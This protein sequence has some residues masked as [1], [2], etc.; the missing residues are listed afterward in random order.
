VTYQELCRAVTTLGLGE[1]ASLGEIK[2][3][4]RQLVKLHH[5]DTGSAEPPEKIREINAAYRTLLDYLAEYR[6]SFDEK[7]FYEQ[8]PEERLRKQFAD[9]PLWGDR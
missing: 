3:R 1:R 5:P 8:C 2:R 9:D 6:F 4:H 7:D